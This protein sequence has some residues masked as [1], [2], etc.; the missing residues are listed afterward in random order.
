MHDSRAPQSLD[1]EVLRA[2]LSEPERLGLYLSRGLGLPAESG[3]GQPE[4]VRVAVLTT[5]PPPALQADRQAW[6][7]AAAG[8]G[9][10][11]A[12][13]LAGLDLVAP[14]TGSPWAQVAPETRAAL[15]RLAVSWLLATAPE[16][17]VFHITDEFGGGML[18]R[19]Q[20]GLAAGE[21]RLDAR[22]LEHMVFAALTYRLLIHSGEAVVVTPGEEATWS[23]RQVFAEHAAVWRRALV[24]A[25]NEG[26]AGLDLADLA[27]AL[28]WATTTRRGRATV[29]A[30]PPAIAAAVAE[31]EA[32]LRPRATNLL[33]ERAGGGN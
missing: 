11:P 31:A 32:E 15:L 8:L 18:L 12:P 2:A 10:G 21:P 6:R 7:A 30:A 24:S 14:P 1:P 25:P 33:R 17:A 9:A 27:E 20:S 23:S 22:L 28:M 29:A 26:L 5:T 3:E 19:L 4:F 16:L 13:R